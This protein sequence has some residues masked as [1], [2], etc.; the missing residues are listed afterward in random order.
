[1]NVSFKFE[2]L[3]VWQLSLEYADMA[4]STGTHLPK[5]EEYNLKSQYL[6]A[7][8]SIALN[9]AE[10]SIGQTDAEQVRFL[11]LALRSLIES[12]A[13]RRL[14]SRRGYCQG[15]AEM[16]AAEVLSETLAAKLQAM[17]RSLSPGQPWIRE[18][19]TD[20]QPG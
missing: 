6:R 3:E 7:V 9:I 19:V 17:R 18:D 11:G 1:M 2:K 8:S 20:Y 10:G 15:V 14:I 16:D 5:V 13:C 4:Y 12:V